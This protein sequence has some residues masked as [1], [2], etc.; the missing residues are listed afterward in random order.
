[1]QRMLRSNSAILEFEDLRFKLVRATD[2]E[3]QRRLLNRMEAVLAEELDRTEAA[4][5]TSLH[6]SRLG[7]EMEMDYVYAP[8]V[9]RAKLEVLHRTLEKEMPSYRREK[10]L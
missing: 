10:G 9:L 2:R 4:L 8:H 3:E 5:E 1:M 7:Y 6:D